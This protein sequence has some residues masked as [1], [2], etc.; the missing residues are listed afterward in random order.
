MIGNTNAND[1]GRQKTLADCWSSGNQLSRPVLTQR[2]KK[3]AKKS[4]SPLFITGQSALTVSNEGS[5]NLRQSQKQVKTNLSKEYWGDPIGEKGDN[6]LRVVSK[7]IQGLGLQA[8]NPK[9]DEL[10]NWIV[11]KNIDVIGL[12]EI[13]VNW[14][15]CKNKDRFSER[16]RNP[17]WGFVRYSVG[18][19]KH[20][21]KYRH[22][23]G[24]CI[25]LSVEQATHRISGSGADE[26]G[27]GQWSWVLMKGKDQALVRVITVYQPNQCQ[28]ATQCGSVYSQQRVQL[29]ANNI[30]KCPLDV[31][32][33]DL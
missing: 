29:L 4:N 7:N 13:N 19:N 1:D 2:Q 8:C 12:Q 27:L 3:R 24:G 26:R 11:N 14:N 30:D 16:I 18:F 10:K 21:K 25:T 31:F 23:Y 9:E 22:Q 17:A 15:K 5:W 28:I 33:N 6:V 32:R 20:D